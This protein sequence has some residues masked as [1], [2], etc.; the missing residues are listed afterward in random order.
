VALAGADRIAFCD[1]DD[2]VG[3]GWVRAMTDALGE[4]A[5]VGGPLEYHRLNP[6]WAV[7]GR[8]FLP[9]EDGLRS[10]PGGPPW[11]YALSANL[12]VRRDVHDRIGGFDETLR[13]AGE[14][15]DYGWRLARAGV[16]AQWVP[17]AVVHYRLRTRL[18]DLYRQGWSHNFPAVALYERYRDVWP[19][20]PRVLGP[21]GR[22][23]RAL[24]RATRV[25]SRADLAWYAFELGGEEGIATAARQARRAG[26]SA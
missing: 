13:V 9:Q 24:V 6:R 19:Q 20:Q 4:H 25:R 5:H 7:A 2:V 14:D 26:A 17:D 21:G 8:R 18:R 23:A 3:A 15:T 22:A 1:A 16:P 12:G 11:P 10:I